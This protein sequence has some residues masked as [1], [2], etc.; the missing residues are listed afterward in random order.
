MAWPVVFF[1]RGAIGIYLCTGACRG[2]TAAL[3]IFRLA[4]LYHSGE[5]G[6]SSY[7]GW[8]NSIAGW[9]GDIVGQFLPF[10]YSGWVAYC[11]FRLPSIRRGGGHVTYRISPSQPKLP[12]LRIVGPSLI[13]LLFI[14][15][16]MDL[17]YPTIEVGV[18]QR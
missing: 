7:S 18:R 3:Y 15:S 9:V 17:Y 8:G 12:Y 6:Q 5:G 2:P 10:S 11:L 4:S 1:W 14:P 16:F 13:E